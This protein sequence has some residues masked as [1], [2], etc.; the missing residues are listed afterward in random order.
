MSSPSPKTVA[1]IFAECLTERVERLR[2]SSAKHPDS[3]SVP[4][5]VLRL[6]DCMQITEAFQFYLKQHGGGP[7][8]RSQLLRHLHTLLTD[9]TLDR[10]EL[11]DHRALQAEI[12]RILKLLE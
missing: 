1:D 11:I 2:E 3:P 10:L 6:I 7:V 12:P 4:M 8:I 9:G 5:D